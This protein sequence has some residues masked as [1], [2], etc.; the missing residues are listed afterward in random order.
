MGGETSLECGKV[1]LD[2]CS[3]WP[4]YS[5]GDIILH[6]NK[7]YIIVGKMNT[8]SG[9][10][11]LY[12]LKMNI[13]WIL[14]TA[15]I[16]NEQEMLQLIKAHSK[17]IYTVHRNF[18][19]R[20][21]QYKG[22]PT[23]WADGIKVWDNDWNGPGGWGELYKAAIVS[24]K[25]SK[26]SKNGIKNDKGIINC[27]VAINSFSMPTGQCVV[28][29]S[30]TINILYRPCMHVCCCSVCAQQCKLCPLCRKPVQIMEKVY[31]F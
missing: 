2:K 30:A 10:L 29:M 11:K 31:I 28:C 14:D 25:S 24:L 8:Y 26:S 12:K 23:N 5:V 21:H 4:I 27:P 20:L 6:K 3:E 13:D 17:K 15:I 9:Y 1:L 22:D 16:P 18:C 19:G 7:F